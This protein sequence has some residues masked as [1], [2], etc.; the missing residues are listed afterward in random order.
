[1]RGTRQ[2]HT[3]ARAAIHAA[4]EGLANAMGVPFW[5]TDTTSASEA[6]DRAVG[7]IFPGMGRVVVCYVSGGGYHSFWNGGGRTGEIVSACRFAVECIKHKE[8]TL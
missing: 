1:M 8:G 6:P 7:A 5:D 4:V 2:T 3:E